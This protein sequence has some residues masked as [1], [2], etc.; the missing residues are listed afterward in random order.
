MTVNNESRFFYGWII[1]VCCFTDTL[2][3]GV[4]YSFGMFI[5]SLETEFGCS[6]TAICLA[7]TIHMGMLIFSQIAMGWATDR[8]GPRIPLL[9]AALFAGGG[10]ALLSRAENIGQFYLFYSIASLTAG[11]QAGALPQTVIQK[12]F[13]KKRGLVLGIVVS[14]MGAGPLV[15]APLIGMLISNNGWQQTYLILGIITG[16]LLF[17]ISLLMLGQPEE[18]GLKPYGAESQREKREKSDLHGGKVRPQL[19]ETKVWTLDIALKSKNYWMLCGYCLLTYLSVT[20]LITHFVPFL[21]DLPIKLDKKT[22]ALAL[23]ILGGVS[24]IG[25]IGWGAITPRVVGWR[26]GLIVCAAFCSLAML[27]L[28][29]AS[30]PLMMWLFVGLFGF[31]QGARTPLVPGAVSYYFGMESLG[32]L[33]GVT[34]A[35]GVIGCAVAPVLGGY[36]YDIT[37]TYVWPFAICASCWGIAALFAIQLKLQQREK[38]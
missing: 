16:V 28:I 30:T 34:Q 15:F 25:R 17:L 19:R 5:T 1:L 33:V 9:L 35:V 10:L 26:H 31:F 36:I 6:R 37:G 21:I 23:G 4:F 22:A 18:K 11:A 29:L 13:V 2:T 38:C 12:W 3:Y 27:W 7:Q 20:L 32:S 8:Y 14:G 24:I